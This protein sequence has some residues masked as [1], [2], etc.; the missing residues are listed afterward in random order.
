MNDAQP[1]HKI[2]GY[3]SGVEDND[4]LQGY[5]CPAPQQE[6]NFLDCRACWTAQTVIYHK[7]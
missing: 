7:H 3:A 5:K 6:N 2:T 4:K 1:N